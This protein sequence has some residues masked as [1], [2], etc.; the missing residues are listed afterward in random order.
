MLQTSPHLDGAAK[1]VK[2]DAEVGHR[3][4]RERLCLLPGRVYQPV[5]RLLCLLL[6][7]RLLLS[8]HTRAGGMPLPP[9]PLCLQGLRLPAECTAAVLTA[10]KCCVLPR[11]RPHLP[12]CRLNAVHSAW[13]HDGWY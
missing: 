11:A 1:P 9:L 7:L 4:W 2:A 13:L 12:G 6:R 5:A 3:G 10:V 8:A